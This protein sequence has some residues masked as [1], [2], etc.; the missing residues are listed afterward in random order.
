MKKRLVAAIAAILLIGGAVA[1]VPVVERRAAAQIKLEMERDGTT[2]VGAVEVGLLERRILLRDLRSRQVGELAI[3]RWQVSGLA[4]PLAE[5]IRGRTPISGPQLGDPLEAARLELD[6]LRVTDDG[7]RWTIASLV[8]EG[9]DLQRYEP[10]PAASAD[11]LIHLGARL[12]AALS[13]DRVEQKNTVVT[14]PAGDR[15]SLGTVSIG[16]FDKGLAG[17]IAVA[18]F[19]VVPASTKAPS[20]KLADVKL[21]GLDLRRALAAMSRMD[22][23]PGMPLGRVELDAADLSGFGGEVLARY[24]VSLGSVSSQTRREGKDVKRSSLRIQDFVLA[25]PLSGLETLKLRLGLQAMG[26]KDLRLALD[27]SGTED[28]GKSEVSVDRCALS[29]PDLGEVALSARLVG[30]D[31]AFWR[32]V[33]D[34]DS[35]SLLR[36][37]AALG[38]ARLVVADRGMVERSLRAVAI[39][40]GQPAATVRA[41]IAQEVRRFQPP[42]VLITDDLTKLLDTLARFIETGGTLTLD[43]KPDTPIGLDKLDYFRRP[44]PDLVTLLGLSATLSR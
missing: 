9:L 31:A 30:T 15:I 18:G 24:G 37:K 16:K 6:D 34:G 22:W 5:L 12:A 21:A 3:G 10:L 29:G 44:G 41:G 2:T 14:N 26:L 13:M 40:S 8:A 4:W 32:A 43:A 35:A 7:A 1:A 19:E 27:C 23:R 36:S 33:D 42:G 25:P 11:P 28:R 39:T 20:I 38:D 17:S